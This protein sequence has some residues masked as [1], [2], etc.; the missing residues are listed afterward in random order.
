MLD[1]YGIG[2]SEPKDLHGTDYERRV[3][4]VCKL[5]GFLG[6]MEVV[7]TVTAGLGYEKGRR[8]M[9]TV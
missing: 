6:A 8:G 3:R 4:K 5:L 2:S 7:P 1:A 9:R